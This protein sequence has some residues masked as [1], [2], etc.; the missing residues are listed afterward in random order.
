[1]KK[2]LILLL[3]SLICLSACDT[4]VGDASDVSDEVSENSDP[5][6]DAS[7]EEAYSPVDMEEVRSSAEKL[8]KAD[9]TIMGVF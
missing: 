2:I 1:M 5:S 3:I 4:P 8:V 9:I 7:E 6:E